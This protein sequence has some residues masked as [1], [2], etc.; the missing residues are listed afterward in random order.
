MKAVGQAVADFL[1]NMYP[2][3]AR[4]D[5][6]RIKRA[7]AAAAADLRVLRE[8]MPIL[9]TRNPETPP[10]WGM[11]LLR[12]AIIEG[13]ASEVVV[14]F[15][16]PSRLEDCKTPND[17]VTSA[18]IFGLVTNDIVRGYLYLHGYRIQWIGGP[19]DA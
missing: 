16:A 12:P 8:F 14:E 17:V 6:M 5:S 15:G 11:R 9:D 19:A 18:T 4:T 7:A 13:A 3:I 2:E 10:R 1:V